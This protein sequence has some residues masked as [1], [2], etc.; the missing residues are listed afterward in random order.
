[1][2]SW[3][4][5]MRSGDCR[6]FRYIGACCR[7]AASSAPVDVDVTSQMCPKQSSPLGMSYVQNS[8]VSLL[9]QVICLLAGP[10]VQRLHSPRCC[11][12]SLSFPYPSSII[13]F[14]SFCLSLLLPL[15]PSITSLC[16]ELPLRMCPIQFYDVYVYVRF[17]DSSKNSGHIPSET[18]CCWPRDK[19][20]VVW[21]SAEPH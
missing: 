19:C 5:S 10:N 12:F 11:A 1:M 6:V 3:A 16:R 9:L 14:M 8:M 21:S 2:V 7:L 20:H 15:F 17:L 4:Q 18:L 13:Q